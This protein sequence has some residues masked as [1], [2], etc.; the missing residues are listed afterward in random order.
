MDAARR[1]GEAARLDN[2]HKII[3]MAVLHLHRKT[4]LAE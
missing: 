3:E 1:L 4:L 2:F